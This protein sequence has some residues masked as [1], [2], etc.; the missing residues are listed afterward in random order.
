M[1]D[2]KVNIKNKKAYFQY[3][4]IEKLIAGIELLGTE[5]KS[6]RMGRASL[7][8]AY[9]QFIG[10]ELFIKMTI[11]EYKFGGHYNHEPNRERKL[12]LTHRE[13]KRFQRKVQTNGMTIVPLSLF[14]DANGRAKL[15]IA[16]AKGKTIGDKRNDMKERDSNRDMDRARKNKS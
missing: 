14:I 2:N 8:D 7:V 3:E 9:C 13:L 6:I 12:L 16:L 10:K 1:S 15:E 4:I 5:I 11:S